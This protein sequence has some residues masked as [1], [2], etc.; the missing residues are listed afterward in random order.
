MGRDWKRKLWVAALAALVPAMA[1]AQQPV[2]IVVTPA[3]AT[4]PAVTITLGAR[5]GHA[6]PHRTGCNHTGG[7]NIDVAQPSPDTVVITMTGVAVS[8][9]SP[10]KA[11]ASMDIDLCQD[12]E[13]SFASPKV[14]KAKLTME[15]RVVG[16]LRSSPKGGCASYDNACASLTCGSAEIITLCVPPHTVCCG[17]N[18]GVNDHDGPVSIP[19]S[20]GAY[21]LHQTFTIAA[22]SPGCLIPHKAP[23]AEFAPDP[24]LDPIWISAKEPFHGIAK[25]DFGY[26]VTITVAEDN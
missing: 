7:G 3:T 6:T 17:E 16:V 21:S 19:V 13:V 18:L 8:Y 5:H 25:K 22:Q 1:S 14:K 4:P 9:C 11:M 2:N 24:A 20:A 26:Q 23:S 15:G 10:R 12:F